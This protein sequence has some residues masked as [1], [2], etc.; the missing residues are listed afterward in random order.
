MLGHKPQKPIA[1]GA[2]AS[3]F[4]N[5][6]KHIMGALPRLVGGFALVFIGCIILGVAIMY[7]GIGSPLKGSLLLLL[8]IGIQNSS[9]K[10][11][12]DLIINKTVTLPISFIVGTS[13]VSGSIVGSFLSLKLSNKIK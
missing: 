7:L 4:E 2:I 11:R 12:I 9:K 13:F 6:S 8:M 3:S 5:Y 1:P 10:T